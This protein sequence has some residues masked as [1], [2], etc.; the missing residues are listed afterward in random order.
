MK[1]QYEQHLID[2]MEEEREKNKELQQMHEDEFERSLKACRD[3]EGYVFND[4]LVS[5]VE[6]VLGQE[7]YLLAKKIIERGNC[8]ECGGYD[9]EHVGNCIKTE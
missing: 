8:S 5:I 3:E 7:A 1:D 9:G 6:R 4:T 2:K